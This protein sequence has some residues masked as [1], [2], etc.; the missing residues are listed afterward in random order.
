MVL[1]LQLNGD[2]PEH[3]PAHERRLYLFACRKKP[4]RRKPGTIR[5]LRCTKTSTAPG[6]IPSNSSPASTQ[7]DAPKQ[8]QPALNLGDS[9]FRSSPTNPAASSPNPFSTSTKPSTN[10]NPFSSTTAAN[11]IPHGHQKHHFTS[12]PT[13]PNPQDPPPETPT[14]SQTFAQK[15]R[16]SSP[17]PKPSTPPHEPWPSPSSLPQPYPSYH[18]D[19]DYETL[20]PPPSQPNNHHASSLLSNN[21]T[22]TTNNNNNNNDADEYDNDD[23]PSSWL[24]NPSQKADRTFLRFAARLAQ[25]PEQV[26]RYD[27]G[28]EPLLYGPSDD[29]ARAFPHPSSSSSSSSAAPTVTTTVPSS[30][31]NVRRAQQNS[32]LPPCTNCGAKRVFEFQLTPHAIS[33]LEA[34]GEEGVGEGMEW[35][36]VAVGVCGADCVARGVGTGERGWV[37]EWV[38]VSWE[39]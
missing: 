23:D 30:A 27:F 36:T 29:V 32:L 15:A 2:L 26:L 18:L 11:P 22:S 31:A 39:E 35:G 21:L 6:N 8:P 14:L 16:I 28:G 9:I 4:C 1:L 19:A 10:P 38:G 25:N 37:E 34:G 24:P 17:P 20:D 12:L 7:T 33:A 13:Q 5:A 3:F